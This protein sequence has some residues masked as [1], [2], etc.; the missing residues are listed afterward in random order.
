VISELVDFELVTRKPFPSAGP[1]TPRKPA[2]ACRT[3][4]NDF[5]ARRNAD[6]SQGGTRPD[7]L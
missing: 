1:T 3:C 6:D 2:D 7:R 4:R 5:G